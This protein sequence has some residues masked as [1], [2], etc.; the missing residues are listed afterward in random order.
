MPKIYIGREA[1]AFHFFRDNGTR[2][3]TILADQFNIFV[4]YSNPMR[5]IVDLETLWQ[6]AEI[7]ESKNSTV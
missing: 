7:Y 2:L 6:V 3:N 4:S 5:Y 1:L